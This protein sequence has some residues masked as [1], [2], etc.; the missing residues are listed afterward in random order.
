MTHI[1]KELNKYSILNQK[2]KEVKNILLKQ[3]NAKYFIGY[4]D[5]I[6]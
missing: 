1:I 4:T 6:S 5:M 3:R 2:I